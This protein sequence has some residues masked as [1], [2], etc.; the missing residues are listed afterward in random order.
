MTHP[1][2]AQVQGQIGITGAEC[3][4]YYCDFVVFTKKSMSTER[5][6]FIASTGMIWHDYY[7]HVIDF[8]SAEML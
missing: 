2:H 7:E 1:Y 6:A 4:D 3:C 8:A 5:T